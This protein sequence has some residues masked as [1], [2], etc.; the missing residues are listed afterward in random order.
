LETSPQFNC[1]LH[2]NLDII[3]NIQKII[4]STPTYKK[5]DRKK[6]IKANLKPVAHPYFIGY[7][8]LQKLCLQ[9]LR[10]EGISFANHKDTIYGLLFDG[11][12]LWEE[13]IAKTLKENHLDIAHQ[14]TIDQLFVKCDDVKHGQGIIPDFITKIKGTHSASFIGDTK[15]KPMDTRTG[16]YARDDYFQIISYMYR[17]SCR[18]GYLLFPLIEENKKEFMDGYKREIKNDDDKKSFVVELGLKIPQYQDTFVTF[19]K[20]IIDSEK[21]MINAIKENNG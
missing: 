11:A 16:T 15:Y 21:K 19:K 7:K 17:Y 12:W 6:I 9:I 14:T 8:P 5:N 1:L 18:K 3:T 4:L 10:Y 20:E 2:N 13:Y